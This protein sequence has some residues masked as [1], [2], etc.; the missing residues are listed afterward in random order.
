[1]EKEKIESGFRKEQEEI[2]RCCI[3]RK[4]IVYPEKW[5]K[6]DKYYCEECYKELVQS[7]QI[8]EKKLLDG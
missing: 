3:C 4:Q 5:Y 6:I 2:I 1:M 7:L 8:S